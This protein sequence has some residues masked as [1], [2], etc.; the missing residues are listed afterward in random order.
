[1][2]IKRKMFWKEISIELTKDELYRA[3][4][5]KRHE[6]LTEGCKRYVQK[7]YVVNGNPI[8]ELR[9]LLRYYLDKDGYRK[10]ISDM[11]DNLGE[12]EDDAGMEYSGPM[13][14]A[15]WMTFAGI[16]HHI[17]EFG[18]PISVRDMLKYG[19]C[20]GG[21]IPV[22]LHTALELYGIIEVYML[23]E[24]DTEA[25]ASTKEE[26]QM[27]SNR[28]GMLGVDKKDFEKYLAEKGD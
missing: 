9:N 3:Y 7:I 27:H 11:A 1:M 24:D 5:E 12:A 26:L 21:M 13:E 16:E 22:N 20:W 8:G 6:Y 10:F 17:D 14:E 4:L 23:Y 2:I 18:D 28:G 15:F 25:Q 19:Y